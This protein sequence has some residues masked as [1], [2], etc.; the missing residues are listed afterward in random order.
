L[1]DGQ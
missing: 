1:R